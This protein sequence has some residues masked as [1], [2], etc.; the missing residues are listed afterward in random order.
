[1]RYM[2]DLQEL[3]VLKLRY[4]NRLEMLAIQIWCHR[5]RGVAVIHSVSL[6]ITVCKAA[7]AATA[8]RVIQ[9]WPGQETLCGV[10]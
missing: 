9:D 3:A 8:M 2:H 1:M 6:S 7:F 5:N 10:V 4:L